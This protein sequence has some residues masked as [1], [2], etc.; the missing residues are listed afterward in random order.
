MA[1]DVGYTSRTRPRRSTLN[2]RL[3]GMEMHGGGPAFYLRASYE[4]SHC[5]IPT[6][7]GCI[8]S[9]HLPLDIGRASLTLCI[10]TR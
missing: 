2:S 1:A 8:L 6:D 7:R 10:N 4:I 5:Y 3:S 9:L